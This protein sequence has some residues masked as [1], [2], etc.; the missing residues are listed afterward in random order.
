METTLRCPRCRTGL[1]QFRAIASRPDTAEAPI[2][3][4]D[5]HLDRCDG[6]KGTWFD[7]GELVD[8]VGRDLNALDLE[9]GNPARL[10]VCPSCG[11]ESPEKHE[12]CLQCGESISMPCPRCSSP[13]MSIVLGGNH[14]EACMK[15]GGMWLDDGEAMA[16]AKAVWSKEANAGTLTCTM[17]SRSGL[18]LDETLMSENG[19][20]C[21]PCGQEMEQPR[22]EEGTLRIIGKRADDALTVATVLHDLLCS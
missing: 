22:D 21:E 2:D 7:S 4:G 19:P 3:A 13:L 16:I 14:L 9:P 10:S 1:R 12:D 17:C 6:C 11:A 20:V 8:L 5:I 18:Q 15:C